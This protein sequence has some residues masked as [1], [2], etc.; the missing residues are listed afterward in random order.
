MKIEFNGRAVAGFVLG[1]VCGA[2]A[3]LVAASGQVGRIQLERDTLRADQ[4][5]STKLIHDLSVTVTA[6]ADQLDQC[7]ALRAADAQ[8]QATLEKNG[9]KWMTPSETADHL[10]LLNVL[11]P[12]LGDLA[13][14]LYEAK[15]ASEGAGVQQP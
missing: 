2:V 14:K 15:K 6:A 10:R 4:E 13:A 1:A 11:R 8:W 7:R 12:G 5:H 3:L 9:Q